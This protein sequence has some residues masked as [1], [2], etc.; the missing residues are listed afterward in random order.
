MNTPVTHGECL[1]HMEELEQRFKEC[2][3]EDKADFKETLGEVKQWI[4]R[5]EGKFDTLIKEVGI[6]GLGAL[7][8]F[9]WGKV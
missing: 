3:S 8:A 2:I 6:I 1:K 7:I 9:L 4:G 5:V